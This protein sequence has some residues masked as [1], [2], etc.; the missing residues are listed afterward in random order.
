[1]SA[2]AIL[3][4]VQRARPTDLIITEGGPQLLA[5]FF[6]EHCLDELF[7]T[8]GPQVAGRDDTIE[9]PGLVA[10]QRRTK[11]ILCSMKWDTS[12]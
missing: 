3:E 11:L 5:T 9:R 7:L 10:G 12:G 1:M 8:L 4:I 6:A 2:R